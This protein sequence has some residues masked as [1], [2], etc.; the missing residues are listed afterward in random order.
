MTEVTGIE[1]TVVTEFAN[2]QAIILNNY[3]DDPIT[4]K[5]IK[6]LEEEMGRTIRYSEI[7]Q[8]KDVVAIKLTK[9]F[10]KEDFKNA[11]C[12]SLYADKVIGS[13]DAK[14]YWAE[15]TGCPFKMA[16]VKNGIGRPIAGGGFRYRVFCDQIIKAAMESMNFAGLK[17]VECEMVGQSKKDIR[18][19]ELS[20]KIVLPRTINAFSGEDGMLLSEYKDEGT[21]LISENSFPRQMAYKREAVASFPD[22][23]VAITHENF[24]VN[25]PG[26]SPSKFRFPMLV[27]S[28]KFREWCLK[29]KYRKLEFCPIKEVS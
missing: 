13:F 24:G 20:S 28:P 21:C 19:F 4:Q 27:V 9:E 16:S 7:V 15:D 11:K 1:R 14:K 6:L 18:L 23:D 22:F 10:E 2:Y 5:L 12:F 29:Q 26:K 17:F 3:Y 8:G 25:V